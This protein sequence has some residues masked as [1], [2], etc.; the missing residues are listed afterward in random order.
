VLIALGY[1]RYFNTS[2]C[3]QAIKRERR[4]AMAAKKAAKKAPAKKAAK[5]AK[6]AAKKAAKK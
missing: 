3:G 2:S 6:K 5:P 4:K 1:K